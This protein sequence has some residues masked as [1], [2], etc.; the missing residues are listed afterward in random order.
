MGSDELKVESKCTCGGFFVKIKI[1]PDTFQKSS[2]R[3]DPDLSRSYFRR[4]RS[5]DSLETHIAK[6]REAGRPRT[7]SSMRFF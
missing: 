4:K 3:A 7:R 5:Q 1:F 6:A 2:W